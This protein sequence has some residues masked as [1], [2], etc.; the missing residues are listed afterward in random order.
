[1]EQEVEELKN[2]VQFMDLLKTELEEKK[3]EIEALKGDVRERGA[4]EA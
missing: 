1:M 3:K 4:C 2:D